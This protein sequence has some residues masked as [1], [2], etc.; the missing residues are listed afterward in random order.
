MS[1]LTFD[2]KAPEELTPSGRR[3]VA[4]MTPSQLRPWIL[5]VAVVLSVFVLVWFT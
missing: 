3:T 1:K 4:Y 2:M 5:I